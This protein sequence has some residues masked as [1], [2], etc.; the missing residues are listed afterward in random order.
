MPGSW[1]SRFLARFQWGR[2]IALSNKGGS[3]V[4]H[5][6]SWQTKGALQVGM[7]PYQSQ[8]LSE[9]LKGENGQVKSFNNM[10]SDPFSASPTPNP[11]PK[12]VI[13]SN[14]QIAEISFPEPWRFIGG[15]RVV[16]TNQRGPIAEIPPSSREGPWFCPSM[17]SF[18]EVELPSLAR[19][20]W[21][22]REHLGRPRTHLWSRKVS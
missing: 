3:P 8:G 18:S 20:M 15:F 16:H 17:Q 21:D 5:Y 11:S 10:H 13:K 22:V 1:H 4:K 12:P 2:V 6:Q 9:L 7:P 19:N 14:F